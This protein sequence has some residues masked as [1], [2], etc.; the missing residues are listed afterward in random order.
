ME[1]RVESFESPEEAVESVMDSLSEAV[2]SASPAITRVNRLLRDELGL[3]SRLTVYGELVL[4]V[5]WRGPDLRLEAFEAGGREFVQ[6]DVCVACELP[7]HRSGEIARLIGKWNCESIGSRLIHVEEPR[8]VYALCE[9]P[10]VGLTPDALLVAMRQLVDSASDVRRL[11]AEHAPDLQ[12]PPSRWDELN[13]MAAS[14][15][16]KALVEL[17]SGAGPW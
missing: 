11:L 17:G 3:D 12:I 1:D 14:R 8:T 7:V 4:P 10:L 16:G 9:L 15:F 2:E 5:D 13:P 6:L